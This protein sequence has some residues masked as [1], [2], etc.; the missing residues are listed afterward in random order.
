MRE[1]ATQQQQQQQKNNTENV[2]VEFLLRK[3][4][5]ADELIAGRYLLNDR[6]W[7]YF[8]RVDQVY[9][10]LFYCCYSI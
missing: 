4:E 7:I 10:R 3:H 5:E 2:C 1:I 6:V 9:R 8:F